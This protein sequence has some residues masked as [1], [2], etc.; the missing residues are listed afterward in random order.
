[1]LEEAQV[2]CLGEGGAYFNLS[3][4]PELT[5]EGKPRLIV[6]SSC[7]EETAE[8]NTSNTPESH[9]AVLMQIQ[10]QLAMDITTKYG[11]T[12]SIDFVECM[13]SNRIGIGECSSFPSP[14]TFKCFQLSG[15]SNC[16][17]GNDSGIPK[18][19][20]T[21]LI[22]PNSPTRGSL[23]A[24]IPEN[25]PETP[26][27]EKGC[28]PEIPTKFTEVEASYENLEDSKCEPKDGQLS[29]DLRTDDV[30][31]CVV[32][33][34]GLA[35]Q[36][37]VVLN[38]EE[39]DQGSQVLF[40]KRSFPG[41]K[42]GG[43][44]SKQKEENITRDRVKVEGVLNNIQS[45]LGSV[46][47]GLESD[48]EEERIDGK[49]ERSK[50]SGLNDSL[51]LHLSP[52]EASCSDGEE[53][54]PDEASKKPMSGAQCIFFN[55]PQHLVELR[56]LR[57]K[58][59]SE[60]PKEG[61][62]CEHDVAQE[63]PIDEEDKC[64]KDVIVIKSG[65]Q[66]SENKDVVEVEVATSVK[67]RKLCV[68]NGSVTSSKAL[69]GTKLREPPTEDIYAPLDAFQET[70][71]N[72]VE[73]LEILSESQSENCEIERYSK[74][75][76]IAQDNSVIVK[77]PAN[78]LVEAANNCIVG[79]LSTK[80]SKGPDNPLAVPEDDAI[81][82]S[83][84]NQS[85]ASEL[86]TQAQHLYDSHTCSSPC[87]KLRPK[88]PS[89]DLRSASQPR[90]LKNEIHV[91][92]EENGFAVEK[93]CFEVYMCNR[94]VVYETVITTTT[95]TTTKLSETGER[96]T[97]TEE[98]ISEPDV[99]EV[100][101]S[102]LEYL[103][104]FSSETELKEF[105]TVYDVDN[106]RSGSSRTAKVSMG[107]Q[108]SQP[109]TDKCAD[110]V[111]VMS[112]ESE[113]SENSEGA[114]LK[115]PPA[116]PQSECQEVENEPAVDVSNAE[117]EKYADMVDRVRRRTS[118]DHSS[119]IKK[120]SESQKSKWKAQERNVCIKVGEN[121][122][123]RWK[124][125][126]F[127]FGEILKVYK[128][129]SVRVRFADGDRLNVPVKN[130]LPFNWL[131]VGH[132]VMALVNIPGVD[133]ETY[134][135]G[136]IQGIK[137]ESYEVVF[138]N[139]ETFLVPRG[140]IMLLAD[141][142]WDYEPIELTGDLAN[143]E[144]KAYFSNL[145]IKQ[146]QKRKRNSIENETAPKKSKKARKFEVKPEDLQLVLPVSSVFKN[147]AF[148]LSGGGQ[149][150]SSFCKQSLAKMIAAGGGRLFKCPEDIDVTKFRT[151]L[152][153]ADGCKRTVK[154]MYAVAMGFPCVHQLWVYKCCKSDRTL[155]IKK[156]L[157]PRG[158]DVQGNIVEDESRHLETKIALRKRVFYG[159]VIGI[160]GSGEFRQQWSAVIKG[161]GGNA[162]FLTTLT[163]REIAK[164]QVNCIFTEKEPTVTFMDKVRQARIPVVTYEWIIQCIIQDT[165]IDW[166]SNSVYSYN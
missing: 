118:K 75:K 61:F 64:S 100:K 110:E 108:T 18:Y 128:N 160:V 58:R 87:E 65:S 163:A 93:D 41:S 32:D 94:S 89:I 105:I 126:N 82:F 68:E 102:S 134:S 106:L 40:E 71:Q 133:P 148:C 142:V 161:A 158:T 13:E 63:A 27:E 119:R 98:K 34:E 162:R 15:A 155:P 153:V 49:E 43:D 90:S 149:D 8:S 143:P 54:I 154:Y 51:H 10:K 144:E 137:G 44:P 156:Y 88:S 107:C 16:H 165:V 136:V 166:T 101:E 125:C 120:G 83:E 112:P 114:N 77:N 48:D 147:M 67:L 12:S 130:I 37:A 20:G 86:R 47:A 39:K 117:V 53:H 29:L 2:P 113:K 22:D 103:A 81:G 78:S 96:L 95:T 24:S 72:T 23:K 92:S 62:E 30:R 46:L 36:R 1:M 6:D 145:P 42:K 157:L 31:S 111:S 159:K 28:G 33:S 85:E 79:N 7:K 73:T 132:T 129:Q 35:S 84:R 66:K 70:T 124:D 122:I 116:K 5:A 135:E 99:V 151:I 76:M 104:S 59:H 146:T 19:S 4:S 74:K 14:S 127:Y 11:I 3:A 45:Q 57:P 91:V 123:G 97:V 52:S 17:S 150:H 164:T 25:I 152:T 38:Q 26:E 121:I 141:D 60:D 80:E 138:N 21:P 50:N 55:T 131:P 109:Y 139:G 69:V 56:Q 140:E 9:E 115:S